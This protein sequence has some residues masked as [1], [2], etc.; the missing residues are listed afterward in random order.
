MRWMLIAVMLLGL[1]SVGCNK[2]IREAAGGA[3]T[4]R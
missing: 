4:T 1:I 2:P 3:A